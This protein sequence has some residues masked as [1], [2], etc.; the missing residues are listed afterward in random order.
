MPK[1]R[2]SARRYLELKRR[3]WWFK[4]G[5]PAKVRHHFDA[6]THYRENLQTGDIRLAME[7]RDRVEREVQKHFKDIAAGK[8]V[9]PAALTARERGTLW[10]ETLADLVRDDATDALPGEPSLYDIAQDLAQEEAEKLRGKDLHEFDAAFAGRVPVDE[11]LEAYLKAIRLADK[12]TNERRGLVKRFARWCEQE[13]LKLLDIDRKAAGRYVTTA[14]EPM[15][16]RTAKKHMTAL[17]GYWDYLT[18]RGHVPGAVMNGKAVES[19]WLGQMLPDNKRRVER[20]ERDSKERPFT[21]EELKALLYAD[22]PAKKIGTEFQQRIEDML[23]VSCL[24]GLRL[25]EVATLW[26][27]DIH[28]E[29]FDL[30]HGKT[31]SAPRTVP[32]HTDLKEIVERRTK[33]K[34]PK[35]WLF[36]ELAG[37]RDPGDAFGKQFRRYRLALGVD[38][39]QPGKRRSLVNFHS[40]RRWFVAQTEHLGIPETTVAAVVGH[41][42]GRKGQTFGG[43]NKGGPSDAQKVICVE[44]VKLPK[45]T[46][47]APITG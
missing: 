45:Q 25:A 19:P 27:E 43:Y 42:V 7:R 3:V 12:T 39:M 22:Y 15:D 20:G 29:L 21:T 40:C 6:K 1:R 37:E 4:I 34:K 32:I 14:I 9:S 28:D 13:E 10:R 36:H 46:Q 30:K 2:N 8:V 23:R 5:I 18:L 38:D 17:R 47:T 11:H 26:V 24:S 31:G 16:R 35:D 41:A 33:G 44:A